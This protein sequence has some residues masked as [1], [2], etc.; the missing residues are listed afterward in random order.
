MFALDAVSKFMQMPCGLKKEQ[1]H[2]NSFDMLFLLITTK[3]LQMF[4]KHVYQD[5]SSYQTK[6]VLDVD[7]KGHDIDTL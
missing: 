5:V 4:W 1:Y 2:S 3:T 7:C 6:I